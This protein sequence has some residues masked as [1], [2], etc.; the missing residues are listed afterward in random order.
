MLYFALKIHMYFLA[1]PPT[2]TR[3]HDELSIMQPSTIMLLFKKHFP[4]KKKSRLHDELADL[5]NY[6]GESLTT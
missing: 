3:N 2:L 4:L 1:L 5:R 6:I